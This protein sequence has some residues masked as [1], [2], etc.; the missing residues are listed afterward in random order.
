MYNCTDLKKISGY[1][2]VENM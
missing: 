2:V 1:S